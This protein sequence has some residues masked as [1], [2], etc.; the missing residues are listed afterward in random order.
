[1]QVK[2]L[3][4]RVFCNRHFLENDSYIKCNLRI[5]FV[6]LHAVNDCDRNIRDWLISLYH[7]DSRPH[8]GKTAMKNPSE[9]L[10]PGSRM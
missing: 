4:C 6:K 10:L 2:F 3:V 9:I 8:R 5:L 1:M 7:C